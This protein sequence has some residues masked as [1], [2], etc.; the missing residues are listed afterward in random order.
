MSGGT[1][2]GQ[3]FHLCLCWRRACGLSASSGLR[4]EMGP[5]GRN[6]SESSAP[7]FCCSCCGEKTCPAGG[8]SPRPLPI[9]LA[10]HSPP[11][12]SSRHKR[13]VTKQ[14]E[15]GTDPGDR[16]ERAF[17]WARCPA[18]AGGAT[19]GPDGGAAGTEHWEPHLSAAHKG[20]IL[21]TE[22]GLASRELETPPEV[23]PVTSTGIA[24]PQG[25][26]AGCTSAQFKATETSGF[27]ST[28]GDT[29]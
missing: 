27:M 19:P 26:G 21:G 8:P 12:A 20:P 16:G 6:R 4:G 7:W 15:P 2:G 13:L 17:L 10:L 14:T 25:R 5:T 24:L 11:Q 18:S 3:A 22:T 28:P 9:A 1:G 23:R 29:R